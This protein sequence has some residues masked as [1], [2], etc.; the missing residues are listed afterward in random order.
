MAIDPE[1]H[2]ALGVSAF[3]FVMIIVVLMVTNAG[4]G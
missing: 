2:L 4:A 3:T 1:S